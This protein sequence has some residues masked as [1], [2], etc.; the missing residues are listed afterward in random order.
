MVW[1][2]SDNRRY[3]RCSRRAREKIGKPVGSDE[4]IIKLRL[5]PYTRSKTQRRWHNCKLTITIE[6]L[7]DFGDNAKLL[8]NF[9][10][11]LLVRDK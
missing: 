3:F 2:L 4:K 10:E 11:K 9:A 5:L 7:A 6:C 1:P 8:K